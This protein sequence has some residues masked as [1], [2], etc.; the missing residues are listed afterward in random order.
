MSEISALERARA[1]AAKAPAAP[2]A[3]PPAPPPAASAPAASV[4][5]ETA[6]LKLLTDA[7][8]KRCDELTA[9]LD[10]AISE[11][12]ASALEPKLSSW[13]SWAAERRRSGI[14]TI[15]VAGDALV[16]RFAALC[17]IEPAALQGRTL[18]TAGAPS[19]VAL[20]QPEA[21]AFGTTQ[22]PR[23]LA[24]IAVFDIASVRRD[25]FALGTLQR[26]CA[27]LI[28]LGIEKL[29]PAELTDAFRDSA[30]GVYCAATPPIVKRAVFPGAPPW[31]SLPPTKDAVLAE[32]AAKLFPAGALAPVASLTGARQ[33]IALGRGVQAEHVRENARLVLQAAIGERVKN[34]RTL[35]DELQAR[36]ELMTRVRD[37]LNTDLQAHLDEIARF[38]TQIDTEQLLALS[39]RRAFDAIPGLR[40][41]PGKLIYSQ[42][43]EV[44]HKASWF[45]GTRWQKLDPL[46]PHKMELSVPGEHVGA[47]TDELTAQITA[48]VSKP[49]K[50]RVERFNRSIADFEQTASSVGIDLQPAAVSEPEAARWDRR[51]RAEP[52]LADGTPQ[53]TLEQRSRRI[54]NA[55]A[56]KDVKGFKVELERKGPI[57]RIMEARTAVM[58]LSFLV[59][60]SI[61]F[62]GA[63]RSLE[64]ALTATPAA[65]SSASHAPAGIP[66][67]AI[68]NASF[69]GVMFIL[70]G[71]I[72]NTV[73]KRGK[74]G[75]VITEKVKSARDGLEE[76][77]VGVME[78]FLDAELA[79]TK[80]T[81]AAH[82]AAAIDRFDRAI[83]GKKQELEEIERK[84]RAG[85]TRLGARPGLP[86]LPMNLKADIE[87]VAAAGRDVVAELSLRFAAVTAPV[88]PPSAATPAARPAVATPPPAPTNPALIALAERAAARAA[89]AAAKAAAPA[90][91]PPAPER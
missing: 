78:R 48:M 9:T 41:E 79:E 58:G 89:A 52:A 81:L 11:I 40:V 16:D 42:H 87:K 56:Q 45:T 34:S 26:E 32:I 85:G 72:V 63:W 6:K 23:N 15:A 84:A 77:V 90:Q 60:T 25:A 8:E 83:D 55:T 3:S 44:E 36:R 76:K 14:V 22:L 28:W 21:A 19:E 33:L 69:I 64:S 73:M 29:M 70:L 67:A 4:A 49:A 61:R 65:A 37:D 62:S 27:G 5:F 2:G 82:K 74:E 59:M 1:L 46:F 57:G 18:A 20:E 13:L 47:L 51:P 88:A 24:L 17:E 71:L 39:V 86:P 10:G 30:L 35:A 91:P 75:A 12:E 50:T 54:I 43:L 38:I 31:F 80:A 53:P 66:W 7:L 68:L